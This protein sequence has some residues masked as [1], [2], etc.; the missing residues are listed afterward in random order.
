MQRPH[1]G[2]PDS[3]V[4]RSMMISSSTEIAGKAESRSDHVQQAPF[5]PT[6][7]DKKYD[8]SIGKEK[9]R[10]RRARHSAAKLYYCIHRIT[11]GWLKKRELAWIFTV[12]G[13]HWAVKG[14]G[15][16][17]KAA[18]CGCYFASEPD[19]GNRPLP[20]SFLF[21]ADLLTASVQTLPVIAIIA[22]CAR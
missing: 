3:H 19:M 20:P 6:P 18:R 7:K 21:L 17:R 10:R 2:P 1:P 11:E 14:N 15:G 8:D 13:G 16:C 22:S 9:G 12:Y 5:P 4:F